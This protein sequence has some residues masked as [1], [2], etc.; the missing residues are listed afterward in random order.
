MKNKIIN[1]YLDGHLLINLLLITLINL[2]GQN[3]TLLFSSEHPTL[4]RTI[5]YNDFC[6]IF[7]DLDIPIY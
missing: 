4:K 7:V 3:Y 5:M 1:D 2:T 6:D